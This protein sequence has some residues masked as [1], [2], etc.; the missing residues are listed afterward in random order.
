M[1][2]PIARLVGQLLDFSQPRGGPPAALCCLAAFGRSVQRRDSR[3][4]RLPSEGL[5]RGATH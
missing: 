1:S 5:M 4:P 2:A 3:S